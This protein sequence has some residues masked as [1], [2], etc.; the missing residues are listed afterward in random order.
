MSS[1]TGS[2]WL[3]LH[4]GRRFH[5]E[6][7]EQRRGEVA[8]GGVPCR[9]PS[10]RSSPHGNLVWTRPRRGAFPLG[11]GGK[12]PAGRV[13]VGNREPLD[14]GAAGSGLGDIAVPDDGLLARRLR[15]PI[16]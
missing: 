16:R 8:E 2:E 12:S 6:V 10:S 15:P 1:P 9:E 3:A 13:A 11:F 14:V 7:L 5:A 4:V